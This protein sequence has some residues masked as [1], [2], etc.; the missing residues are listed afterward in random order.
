[1]QL[2]HSLE[3]L[4]DHVG[5]TQARLVLPTCIQ[6]GEDYLG[7][8]ES[9]LE[10]MSLAFGGDWISTWMSSMSLLYI[11]HILHRFSVVTYLGF[12]PACLLSACDKHRLV[13]ER[14]SRLF[15]FLTNGTSPNPPCSDLVLFLYLLQPRLQRGRL[16]PHLSLKLGLVHLH[17]ECEFLVFVR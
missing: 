6:E 10:A 5:L 15:H 13:C 12:L 17:L 7:G 3:Q 14:G 1:M 11:F 8:D 16:G 2:A 4:E 9:V